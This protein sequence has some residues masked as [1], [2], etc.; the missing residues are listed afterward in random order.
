MALKHGYVRMI[1]DHGI[2]NDDYI[3]PLCT[4]KNTFHHRIAVLIIPTDDN[5]F[6]PLETDMVRHYLSHITIGQNP[7]DRS[8]E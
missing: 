7:A 3:L 1:G 5:L 8:Y 4:D 2:N 6:Q